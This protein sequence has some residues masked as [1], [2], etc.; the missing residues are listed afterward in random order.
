MYSYDTLT[1]MQKNK[2]ISQLKLL[3]KVKD[4]RI[5]MLQKRLEI[6]EKSK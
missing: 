5:R 3:L 4:I 1:D 6:R 2:L